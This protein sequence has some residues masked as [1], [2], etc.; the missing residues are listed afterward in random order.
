MTEPATHKKLLLSPEDREIIMELR[1]ERILE[2]IE[3]E[4]I[5][6]PNGF[7]ALLCSDCDQTPDAYDFLRKLSIQRC[8]IE[9]IHLFALHSGGMLLSPTSPTREGNEEVILT[10]HAAKAMKL[11]SLNI[12]VS[13]CHAPCGAAAAVG[14]NF[15]HVLRHTFEGKLYAKQQCP[16]LLVPVF[17]HIDYGPQSGDGKHK[18]KTYPVQG[19]KWWKYV[20]RKNIF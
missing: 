7:M 13:K 10:R 5:D 14:L 1:S 16:G 2:D 6:A 17:A 9:R 15:H 4:W 19:K 18:K 3:P 12:L 20:E 11:K 8:D